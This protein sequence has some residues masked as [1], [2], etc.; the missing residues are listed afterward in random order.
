[1]PIN[2]VTQVRLDEATYL[3]TPTEG[4]RC[5]WVFRIT[6]SRTVATGDAF[7]PLCISESTVNEFSD[8]S[9]GDTIANRLFARAARKAFAEDEVIVRNPCV[10]I[11]RNLCA[12]ITRVWC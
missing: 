7:S 5:E 12:S 8:F 11:T 10:R 2:Y 1:M 4:S 9:S 6:F 3:P